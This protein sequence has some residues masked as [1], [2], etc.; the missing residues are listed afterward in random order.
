M[1]KS[2][3]HCW[4]NFLP[5]GENLRRSDFDDWKNDT[6]AMTTAKNDV[7]F[8]YWVELTLIGENKNLVG[9]E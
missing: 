9:R 1:S 5:G 2:S 4:G 7:L 8:F 6:G 3:E